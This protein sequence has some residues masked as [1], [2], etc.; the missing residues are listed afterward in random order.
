M[1]DQDFKW[2]YVLWTQNRAHPENAFIV[3]T[4]YDV[5]EA[6]EAMED[7]ILEYPEWDH[8]IEEAMLR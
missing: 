8:K 1:N 5:K 3:D 7:C 6:E 2:I 4:F